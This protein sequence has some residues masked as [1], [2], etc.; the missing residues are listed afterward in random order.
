MVGTVDEERGAVKRFEHTS[1]AECGIMTAVEHFGLKGTADA[2]GVMRVMSDML[3]YAAAEGD[4]DDVHACADSKNGT[5]GE[6]VTVER[7]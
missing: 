4:I 7:G 1:F 3:T 5:T 6:T 2:D